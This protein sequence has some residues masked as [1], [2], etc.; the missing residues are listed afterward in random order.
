MATV[1]PLIVDVYENDLGGR[2]DIASLVAAGPPWHGIILKASEGTFY[3]GGQWFR[4]HWPE[5]KDLA[6]DRYCVDWFRGAY[7]YAILNQP[8]E[9]QIDLYLKTVDDAGGWSDGDF[10]PILDLE[11]ADNPDLPAAQ[12][13]DKMTE[14][15]QL[16]RAKTGRDVTLYGG[17]LM[18][19]KGITDHMACSRLWIARYMS[20]LPAVVYQRIGWQLDDVLMWQYAGDK[21]GFLDGY[22]KDSPIG[23]TDISAMLVAGGGDASLEYLRQNLFV[24][25]PV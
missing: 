1:S 21:G 5:A 13:V 18:Y 17:S 11:H 10:W 2:L 19:D 6:G 14:M 24:Q 9:P 25:T 20:T 8:S 15:A 12:I 16:L 7:H 22:P 4:T 3:T 23:R